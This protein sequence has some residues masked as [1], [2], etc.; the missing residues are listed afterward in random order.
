MSG[1]STNQVE[2]RTGF[3]EGI[4]DVDVNTLWDV[5][6]DWGM[7]DWWGNEL[8]KDGMKVNNFFLEGEKGKVPRTKVLVRSNASGGQPT[9]NRE[10]LFV[11]D[12]VARRLFY[13][14][15]DN[16]I[17]GV[18]NYIASWALDPISDNRTRMQISCTFDVVDPGNADVAR[19]TVEAVYELIFKGLNGYF[20]AQKSAVSS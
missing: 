3:R 5:L 4:I 12:P 15:T 14:A 20:A 2:R 1:V 16:F 10:T 9:E 7:M 13:N 11:E 19:D 8:D 17:E 6:T 18:R